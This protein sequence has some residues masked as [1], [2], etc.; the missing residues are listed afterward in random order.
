MLRVMRVMCVLNQSVLQHHFAQRAQCVEVLAASCCSL[1]PHSLPHRLLPPHSSSPKIEQA[2]GMPS[3]GERVVLQ[4]MILQDDPRIEEAMAKFD[5]DGDVSALESLLRSD[6]FRSR[7]AQ[8]AT[9]R[10]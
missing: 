10:A 5:E 8:S 4:Q 9:A 6:D 3:Q 7:A 1:L 2:A